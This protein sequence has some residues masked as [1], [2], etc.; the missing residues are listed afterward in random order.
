MKKYSLLLG[1]SLF[2]F[3]AIAPAQEEADPFQ[4]E[5][6]GISEEDANPSEKDGPLVLSIC[7]ETFSLPLTDAAAL[8]REELSDPLL[9]QRLLDGIKAGSTKQ[10]HFSVI[11]CRSGETATNESIVEEIY[12]TEFE[13][14]KMP[15]QVGVTLSDQSDKEEAPPEVGE[16][17]LA[18]SSVVTEAS[19]L[20]EIIAPA[21]PSAFET[22][23]TGATFEVEAIIGRD[24]SIFDLRLAPEFVFRNGLS[25]WGQDES[26]VKMP[27][28]E[29]NRMNT[30]ITASKGKP[31]LIGTLNPPPNS[32]IDTDAAN[33]VWFAFVTPTIIEIRP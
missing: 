29:S 7:L 9:Y 16:E 33:K 22:R 1:L 12:P 24:N 6:A 30:G 5:T 32:K 17:K 21:T 23:N 19:L 3:A 11:R 31:S 14:A 10:E 18:Q 15:N 8:Q 13:P 25:E 4:K 27:I 2:S 26:M 28:Y 20:S